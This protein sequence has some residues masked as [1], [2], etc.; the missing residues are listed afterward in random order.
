MPRDN[1]Y[2]LA[3]I[4]EMVEA[5]LNEIQVQICLYF[6]FGFMMDFNKR[7]IHVRRIT[8]NSV[9]FLVWRVFKKIHY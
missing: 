6:D 5:F 1:K 3:M 4:I 9:E 8:Y 2:K 7:I